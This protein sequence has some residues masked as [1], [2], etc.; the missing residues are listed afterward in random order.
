MPATVRKARKSGYNIVDKN[1][2]KVKEHSSTKAQAQKSANARN[3]ALHGWKPN[4]SGGR[5][6]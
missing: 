4:K 3:A 1:S 5:K 6:R 2:G